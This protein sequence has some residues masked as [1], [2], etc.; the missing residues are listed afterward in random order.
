MG[1]VNGDGAEEEDVMFANQRGPVADD[2]GQAPGIVAQR[3]AQGRNGR[4]AIAQAVGRKRRAARRKTEV[5][6]GLDLPPI[7]FRFFLKPVHACAFPTCRR[8]P[9]SLAPGRNMAQ[10]HDQ[11]VKRPPHVL[12]TRRGPRTAAQPVLGHR[13]APANRLD[14]DPRRDGRQS[15]ALFLLQRGGLHLAAGDVR[16]RLSR[17]HG[18]R[19]GKRGLRGQHR[20]GSPRWRR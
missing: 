12:P 5:V 1:R 18:Q 14:L 3:Q 2:G 8:M 6:K 11:F 10:S 19:D 16:G 4:H 20:G 7:L 15:G 9:N 17:Q 13:L